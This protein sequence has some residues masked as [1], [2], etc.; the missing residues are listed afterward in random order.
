MQIEFVP[1][2]T[3]GQARREVNMEKAGPK[4]KQKQ[5]SS[6][7]GLFRPLISV[8]HFM[9][10]FVRCR[11]LYHRNKENRNREEVK[12]FCEEVMV[13]AKSHQPWKKKRTRK[14]FEILA[15]NMSGG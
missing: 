3:S 4:G 10:S 2:G 13:T 11:C 9:R 15:A 1:N 12:Q 5:D 8:V 14:P 6:F 7:R